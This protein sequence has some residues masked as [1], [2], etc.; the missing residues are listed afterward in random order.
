[1]VN[2][3]VGHAVRFPAG[4]GARTGAPWNQEVGIMAKDRVTQLLTYSGK[5][6]ERD[7]I[8]QNTPE[9]IQMAFGKMTVEHAVKKGWPTPWR[10]V[11]KNGKGDLCMDYKFTPGAPHVFVDIPPETLLDQPWRLT[12]TASDGREISSTVTLAREGRELVW[13]HDG[14]A[15]EHFGTLGTL[16]K[17]PTQ[18]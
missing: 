3:R 7:Y 16:I 11:V 12:L 17:N 10:M 2:G 6:P 13:R 18:N 15:I 5:N 1:M 14:D 4:L 9:I 8:I